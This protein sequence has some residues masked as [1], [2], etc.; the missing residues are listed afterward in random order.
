MERLGRQ[1]KLRERGCGP[2]GEGRVEQL[3]ALG[4]MHLQ[5]QGWLFALRL[6]DPIERRLDP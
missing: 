4:L 3:R 5:E 2:E 6:R 1:A